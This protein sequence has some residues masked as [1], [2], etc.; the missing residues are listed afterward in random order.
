MVL[1]AKVMEGIRD[2]GSERADALSWIS[3]GAQ[4]GVMQPPSC[5]DSQRSLPILLNPKNPPVWFPELWS[6]SDPWKP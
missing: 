5:V 6:Q 4:V 2:L 3:F 1:E